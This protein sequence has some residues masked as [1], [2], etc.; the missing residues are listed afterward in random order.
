MEGQIQRDY[1]PP[2]LPSPSS[3][4]WKPL[5]S[6]SM[7]PEGDHTPV[8]GSLTSELVSNKKPL[9]PVP[10]SPPAAST[11]GRIVSGSDEATHA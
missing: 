11:D 9:S 7:V 10:E 1:S 8:V 5:R 4:I 6:S 3:S 2:V